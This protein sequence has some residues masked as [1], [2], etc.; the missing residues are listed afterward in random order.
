MCLDAGNRE[1]YV[2]GSNT[3]FDLS[4]NGYDGTLTNGPTFS[5][6]N[7]GS[8]VFDGTNDFIVG[9][10][11]VGISGTGARTLSTW[12][13]PTDMINDGYYSIGRIGAGTTYQLFE[14]LISRSNFV[15]YSIVLHIWGGGEVVGV[16]QKALLFNYSNI[17]CSYDGTTIYIY[18]D[19][20]L[21]VSANRTFLA[22][23]NSTF[24]LEAQLMVHIDILKEIFPI[25]CYTTEHYQHPKYCKTIT[26]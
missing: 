15:T 9:T 3:I 12:V 25:H 17:A 18:L 11:N 19:G 2:S 22:T 13:Y 14:I 5:S 20:R 7:G 24:L 23:A 26:P 8:I 10:N 21:E 1:S 4:G 6:A 16:V